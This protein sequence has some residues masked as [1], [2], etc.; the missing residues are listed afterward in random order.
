MLNRVVLSILVGIIV[1][2]ICWV[3]GTLLLPVVP[4]VAGI[5]IAVSYAA[6]VIAGLYFFFSG[7][8]TVI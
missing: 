7:R 5:L 3:V 4:V 6:G 2:F 1:A 8:T